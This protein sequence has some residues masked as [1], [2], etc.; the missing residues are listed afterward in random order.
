MNDTEHGLLGKMRREASGD[1]INLQVTTVGE[2]G[3]TLMPGNYLAIFLM[4]SPLWW[5]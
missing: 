1:K 4:H 5:E 3:G 2:V